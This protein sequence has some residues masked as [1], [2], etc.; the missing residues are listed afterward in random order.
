ML[1]EPLYLNVRC[2]H[3]LSKGSVRTHIVTSSICHVTALTKSLTF[4]Y[5][6]V[7]SKQVCH[8]YI[9]IQEKPERVL[10][11]L[12]LELQSLISAGT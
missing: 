6:H 8:M 11:P 9:R 2:H 5:M 12:K 4:L 3:K 10:D 1:T 7:L